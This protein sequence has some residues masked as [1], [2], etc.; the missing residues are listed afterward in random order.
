MQHKLVPSFDNDALSSLDYRFKSKQKQNQSDESEKDTNFQSA[1]HKF[2]FCDLFVVD[3]F[4]VIA[5]LVYH[6]IL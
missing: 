4:L 5:I 2:L 6:P 3:S 1:F